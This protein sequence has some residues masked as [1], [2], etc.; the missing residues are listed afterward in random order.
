MT[1]TEKLARLCVCGKP[2]GEHVKVSIGRICDGVLFQNKPATDPQREGL[3]AKEQH[4]MDVY[5]SLGLK[6]GDDPFPLIDRLR[7]A[8]SKEPVFPKDWPGLCY[9]RC[10]P[11]FEITPHIH[12]SKGVYVVEVEP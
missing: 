9:D 4:L 11:E 3:S 7:S 5:D 6:W 12:T 8:G 10:D 2:Y 1:R